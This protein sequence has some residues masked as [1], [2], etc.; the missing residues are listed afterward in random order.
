MLN[1]LLYITALLN[2]L[3]FMGG[4]VGIMNQGAYTRL[5][6]DSC[7][8]EAWDYPGDS[9]LVV[10]T[11]CAPICSS[12]ARIID[13]GG[14]TVRNIVPPYPHAVFPEASIREGVLVWEDHTP[15]VLDEE[16]LKYY[17]H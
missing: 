5:T 13:K 4:E 1:C 16:E 14:K 9:V 3:S 7:V 17:T 11:V 15:D 2:Q 12:H 8:V 6:L 10:Q